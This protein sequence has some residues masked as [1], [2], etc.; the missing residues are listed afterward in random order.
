MYRFE[1]SAKAARELPLKRHWR[2]GFRKNIYANP[3]KFSLY[4]GGYLENFVGF[5]YVFFVC[6]NCLSLHLYKL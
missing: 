2:F 6:K 4:T 1:E 5:V 3:I